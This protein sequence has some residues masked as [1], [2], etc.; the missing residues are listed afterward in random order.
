MI[1]CGKLNILI[2]CGNP[3]FQ[4]E[5][6]EMSVGSQICFIL[7]SS[8]EDARAKITGNDIRVLL[9]PMFLNGYDSRWFARE[10]KETFK[11]RCVIALFER[12]EFEKE[13]EGEVFAAWQNT[14]FQIMR[15]LKNLLGLY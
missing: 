10:L 8:F 7:A 15:G 4:Q 12:K 13:F 11:K 5:L 6:E 9:L 2:L 14:P 1:S 3:Y